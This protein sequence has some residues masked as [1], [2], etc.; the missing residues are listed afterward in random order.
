MAKKKKKFDDWMPD[1][2]AFVGAQKFTEDQKIARER[3]EK[4]QQRLK[5]ARQFSKQGKPRLKKEP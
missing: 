1:K 3:H 5:L 2:P 4:T